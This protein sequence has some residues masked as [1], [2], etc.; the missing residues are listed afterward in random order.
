VNSSVVSVIVPVH[1]VD[2]F[3]GEAVESVLAQTYREWELLLVDDGSTDGSRQIAERYAAEHPERIR[4]L[5]HQ[6]HENRGASAT[7]NLGIAHARGEY[8]ALLDADDTWLPEKL[9]QQV[10]LMDSHP[11]VGMIY[12]SAFWWYG[13]TGEEADVRRDFT[14]VPRLA[15]GI[16]VRPPELL[17]VCWR[18]RTS[19]PLLTTALFRRDAVERVGGF[20]EEFRV[21][22]TDQVFFTKLF[23]VTAVLPVHTTWAKYRRHPASSVARTAR[24][25]RVEEMAMIYLHWAERYLEEHGWRGTPVWNA[26]QLRIW[27]QRHPR[28]AAA[29]RRA[30]HMLSRV[31]PA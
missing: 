3:L 30:K 28:I 14:D 11:G 26:L 16:A 8:L 1:N 13:W 7:R 29:V 21:I 25:G 4:F 20:E 12:G 6:G 10:P 18:E 2:R 23:L 22:F 5:H 31:S 9:A 17:V 24:A 15:S 27:K 19:I